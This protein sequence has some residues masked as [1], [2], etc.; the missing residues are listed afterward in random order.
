MRFRLLQARGADDPVRV[1]ER[2]AFAE[3][4][5]VPVDDVEPVDL[6]AGP[7]DVDRVADGANAVLVGGSGAW[8]VCDDAPWIRAFI[9]GL[10]ELSTRDVPLFAS[11][12]GYQALVVALGGQVRPSPERAEVGTYELAP[13]AAAATDPLFDALPAAFPAQEGHKDAALVLPSSVVNLVTSARCPYQAL[14]VPGREVW[15]TQFH[16]ELS[17]VD[18][19]RRFDRYWDMYVGVFGHDEARR[20]YDGHRPSPHSNALLRRFAARVAAGS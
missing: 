14:R 9:D 19:K 6:L 3:K 1:E 13:T 17:D 16:P 10:G 4:L 7:L 12:F 20:I 15:A 8:G 18:N 11:C 5:G 2:A